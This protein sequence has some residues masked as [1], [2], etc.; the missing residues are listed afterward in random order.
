[1]PAT[2]RQKTETDPTK[3]K[4]TRRRRRSRPTP[5]WLTEE[6]DLDELARQRCLMI[7][8]VLS[9]ERPVSEVIEQAQLSRQR[10]YDLETR[11]LN[12]MLRAL[13]PG[14]GAGS[15]AIASP[16]RRILELEQQVKQLETEKRRAERLL[17]LT[18]KVMRTGRTTKPTRTKKKRPSSTTRGSKRSSASRTRE[19]TPTEPLSSTTPNAGISA[20][21]PMPDGEVAR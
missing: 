13:A 17:L 10:Y 3:E 21:I 2:R 19:S 4:K 9:G 18:R 14:G 6:R 7:L 8:S 16:E 20:S 12:A 15:E 11:A 1:M 5:R